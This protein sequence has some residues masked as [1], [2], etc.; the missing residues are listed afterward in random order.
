MTAIITNSF[1]R[2]SCQRFL[3]NVTTDGDYFIGLGRT[4]EWPDEDNVPLPNGSIIESQNVKNNLLTLSRVEGS[5]ALL[6]KNEWKSGRKYKVY[7]PTD[8]LLFDY[9]SVN[10]LYPSFVIHDDKIYICLANNQN[11]LSSEEPT[12]ANYGLEVGSGDGYIWTFVQNISSGD[13]FYTEQF[14]ELDEDLADDTLTNPATGGLI[15]NFVINNLGVT[16]DGTEDVILSGVDSNGVQIASIDLRTDS[17]FDVINQS[18]TIAAITYNDIVNNKLIGYARASVEVFTSGGTLL[19]N[20]DIKPMVAPLSGFGFS[21]KSD[22]PSFYAGCYTDFQ[23]SEGGDALTDVSFRQIS[24][25]KNPTRFDDGEDP[26]TTDTLDAVNYIQLNVS[27]SAQSAGTI[28]EQTAT[29]ARGIIDKVDTVNNRIY[30]HQ[31]TNSDN[32]FIPFADDSDIEILATSPVTV[33]SATITS[34]STS[35]YVRGSGEVI[36][37]DN[38]AKITRNVDQTEDIKLVIQF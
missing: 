38:R 14:V 35:E 26:A 32:N 22:L 25:I 2:N 17:R 34:V 20:I 29:G 33:S 9:D 24:L 16:L 18:G 10:N 28:I 3:D 27:T 8:P 1:R 15:Y 36:F 13:T 5:A 12:R 21:P 30:Y 23:G 7:D 19:T 37:I 4:D 31:N 6:P 11:D